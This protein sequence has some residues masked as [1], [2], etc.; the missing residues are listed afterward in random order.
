MD[1]VDRNTIVNQSP[2]NMTNSPQLDHYIDEDRQI[3][4]IYHFHN[5][6]TVYVDALNS[7]SITME[8]CDNNNIR[9]VTYHRPKITDSELTSDKTIHSGSHA[10]LNGPLTDSLHTCRT[11]LS[12]PVAMFSWASLV[13]VAFLAFFIIKLSS[14]GI[15]EGM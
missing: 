6:G 14:C 7:H 11:Y 15:R 4:K 9:R 10:A 3:H 2:A 1:V 13:A 12:F 5:C 8:N